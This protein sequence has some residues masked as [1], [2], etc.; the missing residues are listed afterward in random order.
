MIQSIAITS[1]CLFPSYHVAQSA[2]VA[3][4]SLPTGGLS[5]LPDTRAGTSSVRFPT[6]LSI[7]YGWGHGH[8]LIKSSICG[9]S[10]ERQ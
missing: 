5:P 10:N 6:S 1:P 7:P 9:R 8:T 4:V 3:S 2:A